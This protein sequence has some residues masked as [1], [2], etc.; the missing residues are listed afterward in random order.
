MDSTL[1]AF[2]SDS[3]SSVFNPFSLKASII[4]QISTN[5]TENNKIYKLCQTNNV[6]KCMQ[7]NYGELARKLC[8]YTS[9]VAYILSY[10]Q[11]T[12]EASFFLYVCVIVTPE[13]GKTAH[14]DHKKLKPT[15]TMDPIIA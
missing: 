5:A 14:S 3:G 2:S 9:S 6:T 12:F 1:E 10:I 7:K 11:L 4:F 15:S 13:C 8:K